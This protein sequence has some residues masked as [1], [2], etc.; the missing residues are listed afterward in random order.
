MSKVVDLNEEDNINFMEEM[1]QEDKDLIIDF[2]ET[3]EDEDNTGN[4]KGKKSK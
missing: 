4:S 2:G 1:K 3:K